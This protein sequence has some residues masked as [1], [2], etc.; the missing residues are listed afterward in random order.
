M[1]EVA[2]VVASSL[3]PDMRVVGEAEIAACHPLNSF[4]IA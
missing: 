2:E 1:N 3:P 4:A